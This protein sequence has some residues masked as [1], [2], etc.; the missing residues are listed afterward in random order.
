MKAD[1]LKVKSELSKMPVGSEILKLYLKGEESGRKTR[2]RRISTVTRVLRVLHIAGKD[3]S[4]EEAM[5]F[6]KL[7]ELSGIGRITKVGSRV[8]A[9][10]WFY[11][12]ISVAKAVLEG[13]GSSPVKPIVVKPPRA[14]PLPDVMVEA[15][16]RNRPL[17]TVAEEAPKA[18]STTGGEAKLE[19]A[20]QRSGSGGSE[21]EVAVVTPQKPPLQAPGAGKVETLGGDRGKGAET[22]L[23]GKNIT[24]RRYVDGLMEVAIPL[25]LNDTQFKAVADLLINLRSS[26][27]QSK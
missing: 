8:A 5:K 21:T 7:L 4:R 15:K 20:I 13:E 12:R 24:V 10:E 19:A 27:E 3:Y 9:F 17:P 22:V 2:V 23:Y 14:R 1:I 26:P 25:D 18:A 6:F 16:K 11:S